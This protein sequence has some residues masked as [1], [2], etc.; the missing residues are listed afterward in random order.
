MP[1]TRQE[2]V[3]E[4]LSRIASDI[5]HRELRDPRLG[6]VT[7]TGARISP[8]L[9]QAVIYVSIFGTEEQKKEGMKALKSAVPFFRREFGRRAKLRI[10]PELTF[11]EDT[12]IERGA[13]VF[14]LLKQVEKEAEGHGGEET[15]GS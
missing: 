10:V 6:F 9:R 1:S 15:S 2:R 8:D 11:R 3:A 12:A 13:R 7:V 14:E 4:L 5:I